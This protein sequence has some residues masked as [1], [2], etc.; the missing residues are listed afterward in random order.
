MNYGALDGL[1]MIAGI[2]V[3]ALARLLSRSTSDYA[4]SVWYLVFLLLFAVAGPVLV[5]Y[6]WRI[7]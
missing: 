6:S 2:C 1:I 7:R 3:Y 5:I 4:T